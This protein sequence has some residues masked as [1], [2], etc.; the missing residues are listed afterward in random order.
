MSALKRKTPDIEISGIHLPL[1]RFCC[2][3][4]TQCVV[5]SRFS[6]RSA[7]LDCNIN[8]KSRD[9]IAQA[10]LANFHSR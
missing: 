10:H 3:M 4:I 1:F 5:L 9:V 7:M 8:A 2:V 6:D